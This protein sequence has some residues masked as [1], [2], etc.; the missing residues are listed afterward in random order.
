M[1]VIILFCFVEI[2]FFLE[3]EQLVLHQLS[4]LCYFF[5]SFD[6]INID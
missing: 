4:A 5:L 2:T 6:L 3:E 1:N